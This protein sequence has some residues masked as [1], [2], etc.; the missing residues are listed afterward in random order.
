ML[1]VDWARQRSSGLTN[2]VSQNHRARPV[3]IHDKTGCHRRAMQQEAA[4]ADI[5][6]SIETVSVV[7][8]YGRELIG[9]V[10][11]PASRI[12]ANVSALICCKPTLMV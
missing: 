12:Q 4:L 8:K 2:A 3:E 10:S 9:K 1:T 11:A 5:C 7:K 6:W